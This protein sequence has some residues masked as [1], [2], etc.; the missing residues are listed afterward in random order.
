MNDSL[1][2]TIEALAAPL[3]ESMG[4]QLWGVEVL[5]SGRPVLRI[6][7]EG[8]KGC[9]IDECAEFSRLLG[10]TLDVEDIIPGAYS[11]EVSS[12][13]LER[14]FFNYEQLGKYI[15]ENITLNLQDPVEAWPG[16]KKFQ[17]TLIEVIDEK[18]TIQPDNSPV[19]KGTLETNWQ[20]IQRICL[21]HDFNAN[22][23]QK[24]PVGKARS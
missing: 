16:Q 15:G 9:D 2:V 24:I 20:N 18:I 1:K 10:L 13:G 11:L 3:A 23:G 19:D 12:P 17:G 22:K 6:Y 4:L 8:E 21:V 7:V 14:I 5:G